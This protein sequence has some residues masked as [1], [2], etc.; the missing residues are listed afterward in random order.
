MDT[1]DINYSK[2]A[3]AIA[4]GLNGATTDIA[5][6]YFYSRDRGFSDSSETKF[7]SKYYR[8][9]G[10]L[11]GEVDL[12]TPVETF[13]ESSGLS[14]VNLGVEEVGSSV[15]FSVTLKN[16]TSE[17]LAMCH[18]NRDYTVSGSAYPGT[19]RITLALSGAPGSGHTFAGTFRT[20][21]V[22]TNEIVGPTA[23][24]VLYA[25]GVTE[26]YNSINS[27]IKGNTGIADSIVSTNTITITAKENYIIEITSAFALTGSGA[28]TIIKTETDTSI[29]STTIDESNGTIDNLSIPVASV[30][31]IVPGQEIAVLTGADLKLETAV[32]DYTTTENMIFLV[33]PLQ[34]LPADTAT[35]TVVGKTDYKLYARE[36][37]AHM[38]GRFDF[39]IHSSKKKGMMYMSKIALKNATLPKY[40]AEGAEATFEFETLPALVVESGKRKLLYVETRYINSIAG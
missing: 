13:M 17:G 36:L 8:A 32:V 37:T 33:T 18:R 30:E 25:T 29:I 24:S 14:K 7:L 40:T 31:D 26:T 23:V 28:P 1:K 22:L 4:L 3:L 12:Q 6:A 9:W 39:H 16:L 2:T 35:V 15:S 19:R 5:D 20:R 11:K 38:E 21:H 27:A 10:I 34:Q